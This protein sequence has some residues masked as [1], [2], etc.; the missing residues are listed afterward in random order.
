MKP[1]PNLPRANGLVALSRPGQDRA[2]LASA[3]L[4]GAAAELWSAHGTLLLSMGAALALLAPVLLRLPRK[5]AITAAV[6]VVALAQ[7][8]FD[9]HP[10]RCSSSRS[11]CSAL[12]RADTQGCA[13]GFS[14]EGVVAVG[15][16]CAVA[17]G[18][19][20]TGGL[21]L[22]ARLL[23]GKPRGHMLAMVAC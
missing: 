11:S 18:V 20:T 6:L 22:L 10:I 7:M 16:M 13:R 14:S 2:L 5:A 9:S 21:E 19:Q 17:K 8:A 15:V 3:G 12:R 1:L 4:G 23:L